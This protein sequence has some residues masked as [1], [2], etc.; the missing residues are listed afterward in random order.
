MSFPFKIIDLTHSLSATTP[1]WDLGC[2]FEINNTLNYEDCNTDVKFKVQHLSLPAGIGTH[3]DAPAHC[4]PNGKT[5]EQLDI[6]QNHLIAPGFVIDVSIK[7][8]EQYLISTD[9]ILSFEKQHGKIQPNGVVLFFTGWEKH[10]NNP[11]QY[12]NNLQFP[13]VCSDAAELLL[14]RNIAALGIDTLSP[15]T[16]NSGFP[17]HHLFL[18]NGKY[19]IENVANAHKLPAT[20]NWI[21]TLPLKISQATEAPARVIGMIPV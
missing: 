19:L 20:R 18:S 3:I 12:R 21:L 13:T 10:W 7:S 8:H 6:N 9:D 1:N 11:E 17:V 15:D 4:N 14:E 2:G 5:I 16:P